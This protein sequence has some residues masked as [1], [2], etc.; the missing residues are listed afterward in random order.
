MRQPPIGSFISRL[1]VSRRP[2]AVVGLVVAIGVDAINGMGR[3]WLRSYICE[4]SKKRL[5]PALTH[6]YPTPSVIGK[7]RRAWIAAPLFHFLPRL[8]FRRASVR[9]CVFHLQNAIT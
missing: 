3:R 5:V 6:S 1:L 7:R 2:T 9:C 8:V 4:E